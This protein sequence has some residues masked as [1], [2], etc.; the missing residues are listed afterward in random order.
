MKKILVLALGLYLLP[1]L[2]FTTLANFNIVYW[3]NAYY[4][5]DKLKDAILIITLR[6]AV[7]PPLK[8]LLLYPIVFSCIRAAWEVAASLLAININIRQSVNGV[9]LALLVATSILLLKDLQQW[10]P[11]K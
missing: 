4:V 7:P 8:K 6:T 11:Q 1:L 10:K 3:A 2:V 5:W 9:F